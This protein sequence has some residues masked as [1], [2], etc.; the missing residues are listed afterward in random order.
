MKTKNIILGLVLSFSFSAAI[1]LDIQQQSNS[2]ATL[3][4]ESQRIFGEHLFNGNFTQNQQHIHNPDYLLAIGD[5]ISVKMWGAYEYEQVHTIDSQ[6]N[7]FLPKVGVV[8]L[9]GKSNKDL[10]LVISQ[11]VNNVF[12]SNVQVYAD[13]QAYQNV[14]VF[15]TGNVNKPGLYPGLSSDSLLQYI[16]K[17][18]GISSQ[19][20]SYRK[21]KVL[22]DN[23]LFKEIDL[24]NFLLDGKMDMFAFRTGD[25]VLVESVGGYVTA[26]GDVYRPYRFEKSKDDC[27]LQKLFTLSGAKPTVTNAIVK[28]FDTNNKQSIKTFT[29]DNFNQIVLNS[30]DEVEFVSDHNKSTIQISIDGEHNGIKNLVLSSG[31]TLKELKEQLI[32][33]T[34][35]N[36]EAIQ[37]FRKSVASMQKNLIESQLR[38]LESITL[39]AS[40]VTKEESAMR[41]QEA[42]SIMDFI[43]RAKKIEPKGQIVVNDATALENIV[44][45]DGD[46]IYIPTKSNI[47]IVQGEVAL[48][49]AFTHVDSFDIDQYLVM[50]GDVSNRAN[51]K[52]IIL[53]K[54]N[55]QAQIYNKRATFGTKP[56]VSEGDSILVLPEADSKNLQT[57][58]LLTQILYHI[59]IA[60]KVVLD[61]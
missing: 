45:Q 51:T 31:T 49:G 50:A 28:T 39:M 35:S 53:V 55:G 22:R 23:K 14:F 30:G 44:L 8:T 32:F 29:L 21:I 16:D 36:A 19:Y 17:A 4:N 18:S 48:P 56:I 43:E 46:S 38:E 1:D 12:K 3:A 6:G 13:M 59:A 58:G 40:S 47:V 9:L 61:I 7:I 24:Y 10:S 15:V 34:Q 42:R 33:N 27:T 37:I 41:A 26:K 5:V 20:G 11:S 25:V 52:K 54:P 60:T 2:S 57:M